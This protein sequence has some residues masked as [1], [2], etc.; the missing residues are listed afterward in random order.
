MSKLVVVVGATGGQGGSVVRALLDQKEKYRLR[1]MTRNPEGES[2]QKLSRQGVD[3]VKADLNDVASLERAFN[4]AQIIF[5]VTDFYETMR[6]SDIL[7]AANVE[8]EH[9]LNLATAASR[10]ASLEHYIWSTLPSAHK[11]SGGKFFVPHF[12]SKAKVDAFIKS[13][14]RL[15]E[16]TTFFWASFFGE[17]ILRPTFR[18]SYAA[19]LGKYVVFLPS[20]PSTEVAFI[21]DQ[22]TN[23]GVYV[24]AIANQ[25]SK[26]R[27]KSVFGHVQTMSMNEYYQLW[28]SVSGTT[29]QVIQVSTADYCAL[30]P[31]YGLEMS[32]M[33]LFWEKYGSAAW[34]TEGEILTDQDLGITE[35]LV[36]LQT[37][38]ASLDC[39]SILAD[40][41]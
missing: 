8:Y 36:D 24:R 12:E 9:G 16:K 10:C 23:I 30:L 26:T 21:A 18:P 14:P 41:R 39:S 37:S 17:N 5:A 7:Q 4:G 3:M 11:V 1:G 25:G 33:L 2:A 34:S 27:G 31:N 20:S 19:A 22:K 29:I 13:Q 35:E 6:Q 28:A 38:I 15:L 32:L 40:R